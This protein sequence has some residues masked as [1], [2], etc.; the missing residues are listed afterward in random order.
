MRGRWSWKV[1]F[2]RMA[3]VTC[4]L[5]FVAQMAAAQ[6]A[7]SIDPCSLATSEEFQRAYGVDPRIGLIPSTPELTQASWGPH[8]D[9][10]DGSIDLYTTKPPS[11]ELERVLGL[12]NAIKQ[13]TPVSGLGKRAF[14]TVIYP[15]DQY[16]RRGLLG[17]RHGLAPRLDQHGRSPGRAGRNHA[18]EARRAGQAGSAPDQMSRAQCPPHAPLRR[19]PSGV[20]P[21]NAKMP[22]LRQAFESAGFSAVTTVLGSG[23]VVFDARRASETTLRHRAEG[24]M[25]DRLGQSFLTIVRPVEHLH[26]LLAADPFRRF[27]LPSD[28]K[29]VVTFLVTEPETDVVLPL[30]HQ[31]A[32]L[33]SLDGRELFT[34]YVPGPKERRSW[35]SSSAPSARRSPPAPGRRWP[36]SHEPDPSGCSA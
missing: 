36:R 5:A 29:R 8:C 20:S 32:R 16:R 13:R 1:G 15:D 2:G 22:A 23:N 14:F 25:R 19:L 35:R 10:S 4:A 18:P 11:A 26:R 27:R 3:G 12:T 30:E 17:D 28:A 6:A 33:L 34:A 31:G 24:A 21:L 7:A 9:F